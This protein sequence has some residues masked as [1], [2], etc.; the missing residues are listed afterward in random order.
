M[1]TTMPSKKAPRLHVLPRSTLGWWAMGSAVLGMALTTAWQVMPL[2]AWPGFAAQAVGGVLALVAIIRNRD[3]GFLVF[4]AIV[5]MLFVIWFIT[6]EIL[7][8]V[9]VLPEH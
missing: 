1:A 8:L 9:G 3:R 4:V 6:V 7:S 5:P 2:G